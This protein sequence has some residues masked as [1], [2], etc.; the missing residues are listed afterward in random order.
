MNPTKASPLRQEADDPNIFNK[1]NEGKLER[2][3]LS[4]V[5]DFENLK[6]FEEI[7]PPLQ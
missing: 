3:L 5:N 6:A 7:Y 4:C 2:P 1:A